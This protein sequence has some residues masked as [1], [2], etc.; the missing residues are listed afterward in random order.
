MSKRLQSYSYIP[1][2][3][4]VSKNIK[5]DFKAL[6]KHI[7]EQNSYKGSI[8][9]ELVISAIKEILYNP[10]TEQYKKIPNINMGTMVFYNRV[11]KDFTEWLL[12][13]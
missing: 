9:K 6:L 11:I 1:I 13:L 5:I 7:K 8:T 3:I 4:R 12:N 10:I 2:Q